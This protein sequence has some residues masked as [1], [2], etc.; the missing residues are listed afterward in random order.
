ML[1]AYFMNLMNKVFM[2]YLDKFVV[3]FIDD[4]LIYSKTEEEHE[5]HLRLVLRRPRDHKLYAKLSK[6]EFWLDQVPFLGHIVS[7]GGIMV[8]PSKI[9]GV[10]DWKVPKLYYR[11]FIESF[12]KIAK[13]M[14]SLLE[15]GVPFIWTKERQAA[16][17]ELKKRLTTAPSFTV[18][19]DASKE[20]LGC[21][22]MQEGKVIAYASRQLR[23]HEVNYPTHDLELAA[24]VHALKIWRHYLFGNRC[25]IYTDHKSL[26]YIFTQN[27]L[28]MR[29]RRWLEL[30]KDYD[31]EIHYHPGKANVVADALSEKKLCQRGELLFEMPFEVCVEFESLNLG[32]V[33]HTTE[34][35]E[36]IKLGKA[37]HFR[38][39]E[40]GTVWYKNRICVPD[41]DSIKK[42][43]LSEAHDTAYS[44]HPGSTK[45][46]H[47]LK[48][49][50]W[51]YGMKRAVARICRSCVKAEHQRP[52]GLLQPLK[53]PEW[54]WEEISMDFIVGLPRTQKG[55]N[56]IWVVVDRLTKVA[57]FIPVNTT[58]SG[59][60]LAELYISRI[61]CLH[62]VPKRIISD[63]GSQFTS[64]FWEQLHDSLDS[65]LRFGTAYHPRTDGRT[66]RT[67]Q[68]LEDMLRACA[69]Q[70]GTG[71]DK[72][73]PYAE[74]S[75][76]NGYQAG[77]KKS[78]FEAPCGRPLFWNQTERSEV[79]GPDLIGDAEQ[80]IKMVHENLRVARS[81][82]KSYA[83]V[84]R[85]D[86]TFKVDDFVYLKVSPMRGIRRFNMKGKLS[87]RYIG[88]FKIVE[89][90]GE[91]AYKLELPSNL[92]GIH[93]VFHVSQLK[94]CLRV[95][96][97][98]APLEGLD[99]Q[100]DL[101]Y[102]EHPVKILET[103]ERVTRNRR[104]K[105]C[106]VQWKHHT[107]DEA[108]WERE[109]ELR[110]TYP[111]LFANHL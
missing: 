69:I 13:P 91:V 46:Y 63:R 80:Q 79:F 59:A 50:F 83:D 49:R 27:E 44:I 3:V 107:E 53:I 61:V 68:I 22:L 20:G 56:S 110:A 26:K 58:Y 35:R 97:E 32:F 18:Y 92:S 82:Q 62:G 73:P 78:P 39:D 89:R 31:L 71:C 5:E 29:Q 33:H 8:D 60:R 103:S 87:P 57:H 111:G 85:R 88:P 101:T 90:K 75:Y 93:N 95:P 84:R 48:E 100:E 43:I 52:A 54:K 76:N 24:V 94:K 6:C 15:K 40:Q 102:T 81:G 64:R 106:R 17:D 66:E 45:M 65:K 2:E 1:L 42:L 34:I 74:F 28:N 19:C 99:V 104:V 9:G 21:V 55:Y 16:F 72:S 11:R 4:I 105:M 41:V 12:S 96:E 109:E 37:P 7:K 51:W 67:N 14:T 10:M 47:D 98:Q 77:L 38:E 30:I 86:L 23:K 36:Q 70:Y 108:T 25:E